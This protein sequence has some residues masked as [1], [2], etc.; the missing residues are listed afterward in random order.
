MQV[1]KYATRQEL[2]AL[3]LM[4]RRQTNALVPIARLPPEILSRIFHECA[5]DERSLL[6]GLPWIKVTHVCHHW[7]AVSLSAPTLWERVTLSS[8]VSGEPVQEWLVRSQDTPLKIFVAA[9]H[10]PLPPEEFRRLIFAPILDVLPRVRLLSL[11]LPRTII[12]SFAWPRSWTSLEHLSI[13]DVTSPQ[14]KVEDRTGIDEELLQTLDERFPRLKT[15]ITH[16]YPF[17]LKTFSLPTSLTT[18]KVTNMSTPGDG[19]VTVTETV[20]ALRQFTS[21]E[22]LSLVNVLPDD[23]PANWPVTAPIPFPSLQKLRLRGSAHLIAWLLRI[24]KFPSTTQVRLMLSLDIDRGYP[25]IDCAVVSQISACLARAEPLQQAIIMVR[26]GPDWR[27][28][29]NHFAFKAWREVQ[30]VQSLERMDQVACTPSADFDLSIDLREERSDEDWAGLQP[31]L[32]TFPLSHIQILT[33]VCDQG[34]LFYST[35]VYGKMNQVHTLSVTG[36]GGDLQSS[37]TSLLDLLG[38]CDKGDAIFP[39]LRVLHASYVDFSVALDRLQA[40][41]RR[42]HDNDRPL[43]VILRSCYRLND[44]IVDDLKDL[45]DLDW[46]GVLREPEE[47]DDLILA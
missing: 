12:R 19:T 36:I 42:F 43:K 30:S 37:G 2:D 8:R 23:S 46:D 28:R 15:L 35:H 41:L 11:C 9:G 18:L 7:R 26:G 27:R 20:Q 10:C 16:L 13:S 38:A 6:W 32:T 33:I 47:D 31:L 40:V 5:Q 34:P 24:L 4:V 29:Y 39:K 44:K 14:P 21:L 25:P 45:A 17:D 1:L 22:H 3:I